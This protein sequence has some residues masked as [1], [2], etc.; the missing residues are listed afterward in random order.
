MSNDRKPGK[1]INLSQIPKE[2]RKEAWQRLQDKY[3]AQAELV[4]CDLFQALRKM[5]PDAQTII[6]IPETTG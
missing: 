4:E 6:E 3:P 5:Y 1:W 2:K